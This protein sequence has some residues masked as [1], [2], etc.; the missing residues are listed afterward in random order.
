MR[1]KYDALKGAS[2]PDS[3]SSWVRILIKVLSTF[4]PG[5]D[6]LAEMLALLPD[7]FSDEKLE[8]LQKLSTKLAH[9]CCEYSGAD[10]QQAIAEMCSKVLLVFQRNSYTIDETHFLP[11]IDAFRSVFH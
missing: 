2:D 6:K 10:E 5:D 1:R 3:T 11:S 4:S 7:V 9:I 8:R